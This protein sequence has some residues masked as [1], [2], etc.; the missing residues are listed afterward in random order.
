VLYINTSHDIK[1]E[2]PNWPDETEKI[3]KSGASDITILDF[4]NFPC[5]ECRKFSFGMFSGV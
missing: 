4:R 3:F 5:F 2:L 1:L